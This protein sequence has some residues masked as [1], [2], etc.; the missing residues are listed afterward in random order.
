[1]TIFSIVFAILLFAV[2]IILHELGHFVAAKAFGVQVNEFA[3]FMGPAIFKKRIGETVYSIRTIPL[4]GYCAM[5]GEDEASDN[6]RSFTN[7]IWWKRLIIL[8][9]GSFMNL[10]TG[11]LL[12]GLFFSSV[13][14]FGNTKIDFVEESCT[15]IREDGLQL[16]DEIIKI[17]GYRIYSS[18]DALL[19]F[20]FDSPT[21]DIVVKRNGEKIVFDDYPME[22]QPF[23]DAQTGETELRYGFNFGYE[24]ASFQ[25]LIPYT[26][27]QTFSLI[28]NVRFSLT[29]L[30]TGQAGV[31]DLTGPVGL[32]SMMAE[33]ATAAKKFGDAI[34]T[35]VYFGGF[36]AI[37]LGVMNMLPIP[38]IDGGRCVGLLLTTGIERITKKKLDPKYE[39]YIHGAGFVLLLILMAV[40]MLKDFIYIFKG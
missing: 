40:I 33:S 18:A 17:D 3:L 37:N 19:L 22:K 24:P 2:I 29:M 27:K 25:K 11:L 36:I 20:S 8:V 38:A 12:L 14:D 28:Q 32:V 30:L 7:T 4:G 21:R 16:G 34:L 1:M 10:I 15:V 5:E 6:P 26:V 13:S 9:A 35:M 31:K 23:V 39:G